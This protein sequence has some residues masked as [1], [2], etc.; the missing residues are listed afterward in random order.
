M[1]DRYR[2][3]CIKNQ[4]RHIRTGIVFKVQTC[5]FVGNVANHVGLCFYLC[6]W[7]PGRRYSIKNYNGIMYD[8]EEIFFANKL[9]SKNIHV[10]CK[11]L[12]NTCRNQGFNSWL[13]RCSCC[14]VQVE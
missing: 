11:E 5:N 1:P 2:R 8:W 14:S 9:V 4:R 3:F 7:G 12:K 6:A 10:L 13:Y